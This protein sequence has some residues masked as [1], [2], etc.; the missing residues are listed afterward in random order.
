MRLYLL[1][2][3]LNF[4]SYLDILMLSVIA[5]VSSVLMVFVGYKLL[6]MLQLSGYKMKGYCMWFK[7]TKCSYL[8]RLFML[9]FLSVAAMLMTNVLLEEFFIVKTLEYLSVLFYVL[10]SSL[11]ITNLF[12]AKQKTPLKYTKRMTRLV[13]VYVIFVLI[14]TLALGYVGFMYIPYLSFGLIGFT[15]LLLPLIVFVAYYFTYPFEKLISASYVKKAKKKLSALDKVKVVGITGSYAKTSVKNILYVILSEKYQVCATPSSYNTPLGLAKTILSKLDDQDEIFIAEMGAKQKNDIKELCEMVN[16]NIGII[17][18]VGNQHLLTFGDVETIK[19]TKAELADFI[20]T[21]KGS[22]YIN[23]DGEIASELAKNY[24]SSNKISLFGENGKIKISSIK[25]SKDGSSF[26]L[27]S[28]NE[29]VKCKT[30]LLGKHNISNILLAA[31]VALDLELSLKDIASG[32]EK[33]SQT[34][35]RLEIVKSNARYTII[36]NAYNS[37][38]EGSKASLEVLSCF[39]G[40]KIV[41]TPGLVELGL[42]QKDANF[43]F[44]VNLANVCDYVIIDSSINFEAISSGLKSKNFDESKIIQTASL[45]QAVEVLSKIVKEGDTVLFENDL[46]DNYS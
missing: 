44:G 20:R 36:D 22:L 7:E 34:A 40:N 37:S 32:I 10:F 23:V 4:E 31:N 14:I 3:P 29:K 45:S 41:I 2:L 11:F 42:S 28:G 38:V 43:E 6:Q 39:D 13:V 21:N 17:T 9:T 1:A 26:T 18:G 33:L 12:S 25:V 8:S 19:Q 15:P 16:P 35:H 24:K 46:P 27:E 5:L 30:T